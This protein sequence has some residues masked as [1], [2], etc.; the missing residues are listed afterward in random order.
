VCPPEP[1]FDHTRESPPMNA[2]SLSPAWDRVDGTIYAAL[3]R[4]RAFGA[5]ARPPTSGYTTLNA[6]V[7]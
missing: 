6:G 5:D 1:S 7:L 4:G 2:L 3:G